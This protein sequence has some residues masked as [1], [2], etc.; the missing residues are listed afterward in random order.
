MTLLLA[1]TTAHVLRTHPGVVADAVTIK[2]DLVLAFLEK[3]VPG[4]T[5]TARDR[6]AI[7]LDTDLKFAEAQETRNMRG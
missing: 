2:A 6:L 7:I 1:N 3:M 5:A 4:S